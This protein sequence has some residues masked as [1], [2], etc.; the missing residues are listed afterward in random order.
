MLGGEFSAASGT[1]LDFGGN[2]SFTLTGA[3]EAWSSGSHAGQ[4]LFDYGT[5][6]PGS[7]GATFNF[8]SGFFN[9]RGD[10]PRR[11]GNSTAIANRTLNN[12]GLERKRVVEGKTVEL[13]GGRIN[14]KK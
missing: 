9:W 3:Y 13:S 2:C 1:T 8:P 10:V 12:T 14:K 4:V 6:T 7:G 5:L 11:V